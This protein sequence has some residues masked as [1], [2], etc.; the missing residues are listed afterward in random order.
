MTCQHQLS[1]RGFW[2][3]LW[4]SH[5]MIVRSLSRS[6]PL[7]VMAVNL[8]WTHSSFISDQSAN[9]HHQERNS[10]IMQPHWLVFNSFCY[11]WGGLQ[12]LSQTSWLVRLL[13][14]V[15]DVFLLIVAEA[16]LALGKHILKSYL[17]LF[18]D[19]CLTTILPQRSYDKL[20][21]VNPI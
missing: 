13:I 10:F 9:L 21:Y 7:K 1:W 17:K 18:I 6:H 4:L 11:L 8:G 5:S 2:W 14:V 16:S 19:L 15:S 20:N 3:G 12:R